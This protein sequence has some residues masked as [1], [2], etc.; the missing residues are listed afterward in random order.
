MSIAVAS[1]SDNAASL[2]PLLPP[3]RVTEARSGINAS[4]FR[5]PTFVTGGLPV[6]FETITTPNQKSMT[7]GA[8][9]A[10]VTSQPSISTECH[11]VTSVEY[12][13]PG[14]EREGKIGAYFIDSAG[15]I[16]STQMVPGG[17]R[18]CF[19]PD[20]TPCP[21][22]TATIT[23]QSST[24][25]GCHPVTSVGYT[26]PGPDGNHGTFFID[27]N[28]NACS[29][30]TSPGGQVDQSRITHA[31]PSPLSATQTDV[32]TSPTNS[33]AASTANDHEPSPQPT[34]SSAAATGSSAGNAS[35]T[36]TA[37]RPDG[38]CGLDE[39]NKAICDPSG[40]YGGCC[41]Q[42][43]YCGKTNDHCGAGCLSGCSGG[44]SNT[45]VARTTAEAV[46]NGVVVG[47]SG[48]QVT[49]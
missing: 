18:I 41:S 17:H 42:Y 4:G 1:T 16:C 32:G 21:S 23:S 29:T 6:S 45:T 35:T 14:P 5:T 24:E 20:P 3:V 28:G 15:H 38:R 47:P 36:D 27:F 22:S 31:T 34:A 2:P 25:T 19:L 43:G 30:Q 37:P 39:F 8:T 10:T 44:S 13:L 40:E 48:P 11:P 7:A 12:A 26:L 33:L 46:T 9:T 49:D